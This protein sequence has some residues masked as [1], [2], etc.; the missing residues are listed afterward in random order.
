MMFIWVFVFMI[1]DIV[2]QLD[3]GPTKITIA[4][5]R[6]PGPFDP[7]WIPFY[8]G[9]VYVLYQVTIDKK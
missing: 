3:F 6:V 7:V 4:D 8:I 9:F 5:Y 1:S 2:Q